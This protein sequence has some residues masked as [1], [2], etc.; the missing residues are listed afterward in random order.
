MLLNLRESPLKILCFLR[1]LCVSR[2]CFCFLN[3]KKKSGWLAA[4]FLLLLY[5]CAQKLIFLVQAEGH[6]NIEEHG[7]RLAIFFAGFEQPGFDFFQGLFIEA[8]S[9]RSEH[10]Q[11][12]RASVGA[13]DQPQD[14]GSFVA[15]AGGPRAP[16]LRRGGG[17]VSARGRTAAPRGTQPRP[18]SPRRRP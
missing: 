10:A 3:Y 14:N 8:H 6:L 11:T 16:P 4:L 13:D 9:Q 18:V 2:F 15:G 12:V 7:N 5:C 1:Y 17:V